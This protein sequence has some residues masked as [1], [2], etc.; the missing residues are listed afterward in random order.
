[1]FEKV[2]LFWPFDPLERE[3]KKKP[4]NYM[5]LYRIPTIQHQ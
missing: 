5:E 3:K 1:M 4:I 2:K